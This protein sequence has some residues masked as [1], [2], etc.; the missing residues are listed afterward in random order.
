MSL[1]FVYKFKNILLKWRQKSKIV[2]LAL[3]GTIHGITNSGG[4]MLSIIVSA[5]NK[6][7]INQ[8]RYDITFSYLFLALFQYT[9]FIFYF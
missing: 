9:V 4:T 2:S 8:S 3:I 1:L 6:H 7:Q 5:L